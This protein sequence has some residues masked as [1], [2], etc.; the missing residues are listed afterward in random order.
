MTAETPSSSHNPALIIIRGIPGGGK[1]Y[2]ATA[3]QQLIG[4]DKVAIVDP[5][6]IPRGSDAYNK[7]S[8][9][10]T[11]DGIDQKFH[12]YRYL[13]AN[14]YDAITSHHIV[15]WNQ[16]FMDFDGLKIT[17]ERLRSF[18]ADQQ[19]QFPVLIVEVEIDKK[20]ARQRVAARQESGG[21][22]VPVDTFDRFVANYHSFAGKEYPTITVDGQ[23]DIT[24]SAK[25]VFDRLRT[26]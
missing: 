11:Q 4:N 2:L 3:L 21:H 1:S 19:L 7:F 23:A 9:S 18:A 20:T 22:D 14:A 5:D 8:A 10:L 25:A 17:V 13:R 24:L 12:R 16:A 26:I 15:I 6:T